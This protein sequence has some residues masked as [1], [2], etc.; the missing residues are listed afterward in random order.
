[1]LTIGFE[2]PAGTSEWMKTLN[3]NIEVMTQKLLEQN[4]ILWTARVLPKTK[5]SCSAPNTNSVSTGCEWYQ[6]MQYHNFIF[7]LLGWCINSIL[8]RRG[9][10]STGWRKC[11]S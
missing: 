5:E 9:F 8:C 3:G 7:S 4:H 2:W 10:L 6:M 1:V 11:R